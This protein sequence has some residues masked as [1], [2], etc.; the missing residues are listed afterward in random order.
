M[1][2]R[3][4]ALLCL[5]LLAAGCAT[6]PTHPDAFAF[7]IMG[8]TPYSEAEEAQFAAMMAR[9]DAQPLAFAVH[10]GDFKG[11]GSCSDALYARRRAQLDASAHP[12]VLTPGDN[13]WTDCRG[14]REDPLERL[15]RLRQVFFADRFS[16]GRRRLELFVQQG[17]L[18]EG[19]LGCECAALPENR[20]WSRAGVRF[21]TLHVVGSNNNVGFD[22]ANDR[23]A[24][25]RDE[26]NAAWLEHVL[27][28]SERSETRALV[29]IL[30]ANPVDG[31]RAVYR[32]LV[33]RIAQ[34][35][36]RLAKPVL[37]IHGDTHVQREDMP[38]KD[39]LGNVLTGITR[40][41]TFGSPFV[42]WIHVTVDP[43]DPQVF[44]ISP[45][46]QGIAAH[47]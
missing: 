6:R 25:C 30:H 12:L 14:A 43:D 18:R 31:R 1:A 3:L 46:L 13:D 21:V 20:F 19:P 23:E 24:R 7:A 2:R 40:L 41:E 15:A 29:I 26:A 47:R 35:S 17:C 42:G 36:R 8:D 4:A 44:R 28:A 34:A 22:A 10:V 16:L 45:R 27:R 11:G 39:S 37:M 5:V 9:L 32:E 38:F 33:Q